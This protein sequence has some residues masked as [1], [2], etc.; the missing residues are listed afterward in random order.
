MTHC[1]C[2]IV[3]AADDLSV[4]QSLEALPFI[5]RPARA[6][7]GD[8]PYRIG[9][10]TIGMRQNPYGS[11]TSANPAHR[12]IPMATED[13]R[14]RGLFA[15]AWLVGYAA[16]T[17]EGGLEALTVGA[18]TGTFGLIDEDGTGAVAAAI[19]CGPWPRGLG[20]WPSPLRP[21]EPSRRVL[22][23]AADSAG[24]TVIWLANVTNRPQTVQLGGYP[25]PL[26]DEIAVPTSTASSPAGNLHRHAPD[27]S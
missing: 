4:M 14:Q 13:P 19:P 9:P 22:A 1:T 3:H 7:V 24:G 6:I 23:I 16:A 12:R 5:V 21:I 17:A 11:R 18:L 20:R 2:P 27:C 25:T 15:A 8:R 26:V 10:S